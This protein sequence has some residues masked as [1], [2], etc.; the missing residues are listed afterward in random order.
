ML[1]LAQTTPSL[2][3]SLHLSADRPTVRGSE[4]RTL[5]VQLPE[6]ELRQIPH[7]SASL[8]H[9]GCPGGDIRS[10]N[11]SFPS[12]LPFTHSQVVST[13][14]E[15]L[16]LRGVWSRLRVGG[17]AARREEPGP[18]LR[19][20][21]SLLCQL[22]LIRVFPYAVTKNPNDF[23]GQPTICWVASVTS[24]RTAGYPSCLV[25]VN[26]TLNARCPPHRG[27]ASWP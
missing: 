4:S 13:A 10:K 1:S 3:S 6:C 25:G 26:G 12:R 7:A 11:E 15:G 27:R 8:R 20:A 18:A 9:Q 21:G 5:P 24:C 16:S 22:Y 17:R 19:L 2:T 23:F 14:Q